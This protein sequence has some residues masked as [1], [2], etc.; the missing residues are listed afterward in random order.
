MNETCVIS[1]VGMVFGI[2][3]VQGSQ[4]LRCWPFGVLSISGY[5]ELTQKSLEETN[6][7]T[8]SLAD[9]TILWP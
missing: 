5:V 7:Q 6:A 9:A 4:F 2:F 8:S 1:E 3:K